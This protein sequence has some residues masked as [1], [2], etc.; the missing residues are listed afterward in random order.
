MRPL[1]LLRVI[2]LNVIVLNVIMLNVIMLNG[3]VPQK[4]SSVTNEPF[5]LSVIML[6]VLM[7]NVIILNVIMLKVVVPQ[8]GLIT[9]TI[10]PSA[11]ITIVRMSACF[12]NLEHLQNEN[13][14]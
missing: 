14:I 4:M 7:L 10:R 11:P 6:N 2:M 3:V 9:L 12:S 1:C 13:K 8:K 5:M